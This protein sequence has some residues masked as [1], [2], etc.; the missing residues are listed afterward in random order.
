MFNL[1]EMEIKEILKEAY[2]GNDF[3][4]IYYEK[5]NNSNIVLEDNKINK[6]NTGISEGI[7][8][9]IVK[10]KNTI[11]GYTNDI[12]YKSLI[13]L[14]IKLNIEN[15]SICKDD[16]FIDLKKEKAL[17]NIKIKYQDVKTIDKI[18]LLKAADKIAKNITE[19]EIMQFSGSY[20]DITKNIIIINTNGKYVEEEINRAVLRY[21]IIL[22][23]E[24]NIQTGYAST[25]TTFGFEHFTDELNENI[26]KEAVKTAETMLNAK[27]SIKGKM[28]V[29]LA[30]K[31]GGTMIHEACGHGLELDLVQD[32]ISIYKN[33]YQKKV[34]N[35]KVTVIDSGI[36]EGLYGSTYFDGEGNKT[37]SN[38][39]IENGILKSYMNNYITAKKENVEF[40]GNGRRQGY[41][42]IPIPRMTNTYIKPG[43]DK[44]EDILKSIKKG[45]YV[46]KMGGGQV[47]TLTGEFVFSAVES[48]MI[49]NG[50]ITYPVKNITLI[51][52]GKD[53]LNNITAVSDDLCF[54][55]GTCGKSGQGVPVTTGQP[56]I[57]I[58]DIIVG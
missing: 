46:T 3:S 49:E 42:N 21:N 41:Q 52:N 53:V 36:L 9:R 32:D 16:F 44:F 30:G 29:L 47:D 8:I 18:N 48:Y 20:S 4:E 1:S 34:A 7:G 5:N 27:E 10:G 55:I 11:Y 33:M 43:N 6:I 12:N 15:E 26:V 22:K 31:A 50:K 23:N 17:K 39:L 38:I 14:A 24:N 58:K 25:G 56:T 45:V 28:D 37:K 35:E 2:K 40:S 13:S 51:G 57:L 54:I 19:K